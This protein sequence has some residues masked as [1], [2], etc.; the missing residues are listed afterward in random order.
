M[1]EIDLPVKISEVPTNRP[2]LSNAFKI[3]TVWEYG[4]TYLRENFNFKSDNDKEL[5]LFINVCK[6]Y[7]ALRNSDGYDRWR[8]VVT[9]TDSI[10]LSLGSWDGKEYGTIKDMTDF[11]FGG[12]YPAYLDRV[13]IYYYDNNGI[14]YNADLK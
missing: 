12:D 1:S 9:I 14:E 7:K 5:E 6:F 3:K 4:D 2:K 11:I 8:D 10:G 13:E